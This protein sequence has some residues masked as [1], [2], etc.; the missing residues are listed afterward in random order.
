[1]SGA[2]EEMGNFCF[3][4][5]L[6]AYVWISIYTTVQRFGGGEDVLNVFEMG[7]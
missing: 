3:I 4:F 6:I 7:L 2:T 1:M 5:F